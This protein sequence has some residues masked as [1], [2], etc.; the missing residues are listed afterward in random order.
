[1]TTIAYD[2]SHLVGDRKMT[3]N[4]QRSVETTKVFRLENN[5]CFQ[6]VGFTG[7]PEIIYRLLDKLENNDYEL[8]WEKDDFT[9]LLIDHIGG[10]WIIEASGD[11][12]EADVPWALGSGA[13]AAHGAMLAGAGADKAVFIAEQLDVMTGFGTD[14]IEIV[15]E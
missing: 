2:G 9:A 13:L 7:N 10:C 11:I 14:E 15:T 12:T 5:D 8:E 3:Y 1:M 4:S 6:A